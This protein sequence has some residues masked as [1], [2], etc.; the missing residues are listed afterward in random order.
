MEP[1]NE[2]AQHEGWAYDEA[3][4][5]YGVPSGATC[6]MAKPEFNILRDRRK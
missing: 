2:K 1:K 3:E 5:R 4:K 6:T